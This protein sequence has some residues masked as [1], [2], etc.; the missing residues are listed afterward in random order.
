MTVIAGE[1][2]AGDKE[3]GAEA[4]AAAWRAKP[5]PD[6]L[7]SLSL[8]V[9]ADG[10][11]IL[12]YSQWTIEHPTMDLPG[13]GAYRLY[14]GERQTVDRTPGAIV[15]VRVDTDGP[16]IARTWIDAVF[17]AL[18]SDRALPEGGIGG[19]FHI[20]TDGTQVLNY[21]EWETAEAH[22]RAMAANDGSVS[23]GPLW[24]KVRTMPG[25][26]PRSVTRFHLYATLTP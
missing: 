13:G 21:A 12:H 16:E 26:H 7:L 14:R 25:V 2:E 8:F 3:A 11:R 15:T 4:V 5:W 6:G 24:D 10:D 20:S 17:D 22:R 18:A 1:W 19:F 9:D 23:R